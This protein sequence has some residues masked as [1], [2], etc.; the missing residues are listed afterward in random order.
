[1]ILT[2]RQQADAVELLYVNHKGHVD[3][4]TSLVERK[5]RPAHEL[6]LAKAQLPGI[7]AAVNTLR[8]IEKNEAAFRALL[9]KQ[10]QDDLLSAG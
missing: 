2:I 3:N 6:N 8:F 5:R 10:P 4:L 9:K 1:M 7:A